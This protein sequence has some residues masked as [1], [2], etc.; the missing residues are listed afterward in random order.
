MNQC[1]TPNNLKSLNHDD[2]QNENKNKDFNEKLKV[3]PKIGLNI[4]NENVSLNKITNPFLCF[5]KNKLD[6]K[7]NQSLI[8]LLE[9]KGSFL[10]Q[11]ENAENSI[12]SNK[13][14]LFII[15]NENLFF[16]KIHCKSLKKS[17]A[18]PNLK[19]PKFSRPQARYSDPAVYFEQKRRES[20]CFHF[21]DVQ[22]RKAVAVIKKIDVLNKTIECSQQFR[23]E[24]TKLIDLF[25]D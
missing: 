13:N 1:K 23:D 16:D 24:L 8:P 10:E 12:Q 4:K 14:S 20:Q 6:Q 25:H 15:P 18:N 22:A 11:S 5:P 2:H 9:K 21:P 17:T 7:E 19:K 3:I